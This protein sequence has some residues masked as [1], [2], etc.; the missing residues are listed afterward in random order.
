MRRIAKPL[1]P[2]AMALS[3]LLA[4]CAAQPGSSPGSSAGTIDHPSGDGLVLRLSYSGGFVGPGFD[5]IAFP[6]FSLAGDGRVFVPGAQDAIFPGPALPAV[7]VR[8]LTASGIEA[9]LQEVVATGLFGA[10]VEYRGAQNCVMDASDAILTLNAGGRDVKVVVYGLGTLPPGRACPGVSSGE[11][12]AHASLQHLAD[13]LTNLEAWLPESAW[14]EPQWRL[15]QPEALRL[16]VRNADPDPPDSSGIA[17]PLV[18]WPDDA[19]PAT[20]GQP[21][22]LGDQRC[23][24]LTSQRASDWYTA[25][26]AANQLTRFTRDGHRYQVAVRLLLPDEPLE[27]PTGAA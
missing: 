14:A 19:D 16:L 18:D 2:A 27:C 17:N 26:Q 8:R 24:V 22:T 10:S 15:Y 11:I 3:M 9:V 1:L 7:M 4:A 25:L 21:G 23:G 12:A 20:F 6:P 5:L 13:R